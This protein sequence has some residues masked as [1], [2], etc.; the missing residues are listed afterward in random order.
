MRGG[1]PSAL[2]APAAAQGRHRGAP[3]SGLGPGSALA[4]QRRSGAEWP[5][6]GR[7][8]AASG[9]TRLGPAA[10]ASRPR[11]SPL[12][13]AGRRDSGLLGCRENPASRQAEATS[14]TFRKSHSP[15]RRVAC[16]EADGVLEGTHGTEVDASTSQSRFRPE[17]SV[18]RM[19]LGFKGRHPIILEGWAV[20]GVS[21]VGTMGVQGADRWGPRLSIKP[22]P[23]QRRAPRLRVAGDT[24]RGVVLG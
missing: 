13:S 18:P 4:L 19:K 12:R 16:R 22:P 1:S 24:G 9:H 10:P 14:G 15:N 2:G 7:G 17:G 5:P 23:V 11:P 3:P 21:R 6:P 8:A 20:A